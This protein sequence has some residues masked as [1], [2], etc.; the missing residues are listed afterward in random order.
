M[1]FDFNLSFEIN[2]AEIVSSYNKKDK[3][4]IG[5]DNYLVLKAMYNQHYIDNE[6]EKVQRSDGTFIKNSSQRAWDLENR[7]GVVGIQSRWVK[8][9]RADYKQYWISRK[10]SAE[11]V[12]ENE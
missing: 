10:E 7:F 8:G 1:K 9:I 12:I 4:T 3:I 6:G 11:K 5:S 2:V